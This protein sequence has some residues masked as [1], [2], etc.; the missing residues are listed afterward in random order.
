MLKK[1]YLKEIFPKL[2][3]A[4]IKEGIFVGPQI[5]QLINDKS[6]EQ[7]QHDQEK[8]GYTFFVNVVQHI[9]GNHKSE[10]YKDLIN[11]LIMSYKALE[12]NMSL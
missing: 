12:C 8:V 10:N 1:L 7:K 5:R 6:F 11:K 4:K 9:L 2:S 3:E